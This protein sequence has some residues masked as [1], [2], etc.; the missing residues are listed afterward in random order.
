MKYG[1]SL[2]LHDRDGDVYEECVLVHV[3]EDTILKFKSVE[4]LDAFA[5]KIK[6]SIREIKENL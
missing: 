2:N 1:W 3:G 5:D 6:G 4:E